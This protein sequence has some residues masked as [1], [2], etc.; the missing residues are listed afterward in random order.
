MSASEIANIYS[1]INN[2][3]LGLNEVTGN[4]FSN[5]NQLSRIVSQ[6][7]NIYNTLYYG[8]GNLTTGNLSVSANA[9]ISGN[10]VINNGNVGIGKTNPRYA[11]D[12]VG[13]ANITGLFYHNGNQNQSI[14]LCNNNPY[15]FELQAGDLGAYIDFHTSPSQINDYDSRIIATGGT[16]A[17]GQG[18]ITLQAQNVS[19]TGSLSTNGWNSSPATHLGYQSLSGV[20]VRNWTGIPSWANETTICVENASLTASANITIQVGISS[21]YITTGYVC[22]FTSPLFSTTT[23]TG[24]TTGV[25][26]WNPSGSATDFFSALLKFAYLGTNG[27]THYYNITGSGGAGPLAAVNL[28]LFWGRIS[29][30][31]KI[32]SIR[33]I[34]ASGTF[35]NGYAGVYYF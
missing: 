12:M 30:S 22:G 27:T 31:E 2:I 14:Y 7:A 21:G 33:V 32:N 5:Y 11:F 1:S 15:S 10:L 19:I 6:Q 17:T 23:Y 28:S 9:L 26:L 18:N 25:T 29:T 34:G 4:N 24:A 20:S 16:S 8:T 3:Q 35:D 13:T